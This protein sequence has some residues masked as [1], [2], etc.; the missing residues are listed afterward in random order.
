MREE[1]VQADKSHVLE[2]P[3]ACRHWNTK[4]KRLK[5]RSAELRTIRLCGTPMRQF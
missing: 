2:S 3:K 1:T 5:I 4:E